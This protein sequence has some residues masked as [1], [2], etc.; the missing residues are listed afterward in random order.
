MTRTVLVVGASGLVGNAILQEFRP[1]FET[2]GTY[3]YHPHLSLVHLDLRDQAEVVSVLDS[4]NPDVILCPAAMP[5]VEL[6]ETNPVLTR[7]VNVLGLRNLVMAAKSRHVLLIYFSSDYVFDGEQGPY[8]EDDNCNPL[9]EYGRQKLDCER[10]VAAQMNEYLIV[11]TSGVYGWEKQGKNFVVK[12]IRKVSAGSAFAVPSDQIITPIYAPDLAHATRKFVAD[13]HRGL[14]HIAGGRP[15]P[16]VEFAYVIA[17]VFDL[18]R[19]LISPVLTSSLELHA[20]RPRSAG[21]RIDKAQAL[22]D[23]ALADP[24]SGLWTMKKELESQT[25]SA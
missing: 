13:G 24:Q 12:L 19:S 3:C 20:T 17:N 5:D 10:I 11:R 4:T 1:Y 6:C 14:F 9:N 21:L 23:F 22:L 2:V 18:N 16:R 25:A 7:Q 8:S 15:L